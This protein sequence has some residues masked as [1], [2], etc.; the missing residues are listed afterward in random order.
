MPM[1]TKYEHRLSWE[2]P[3]THVVNEVERRYG[4][5]AWKTYEWLTLVDESDWHTVVVEFKGDVR[6]DQYE[7]LKQWA[8]TMEQPIRN[9]HLERRVINIAEWQ[10][11]DD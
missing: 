11:Y 2:V 9:V 5:D 8:T 3:N 6:M 1:T 7:T 10:N 4:R